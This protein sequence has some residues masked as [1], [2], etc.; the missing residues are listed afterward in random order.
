MMRVWYA[1]SI[2]RIRSSHTSGIVD[3]LSPRN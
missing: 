3:A 1:T 2:R